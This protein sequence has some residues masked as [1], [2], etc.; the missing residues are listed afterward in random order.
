MIEFIDNCV[1][2]GL[3]CL[4]SSCQYYARDYVCCDICREPI[5][6]AE[7]EDYSCIEYVCNTCYE[8]IKE[9]DEE[10]LTSD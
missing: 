8:K 1:D 9:G 4:H 7:E 2:C 5:R 3:P 6:P 10:W